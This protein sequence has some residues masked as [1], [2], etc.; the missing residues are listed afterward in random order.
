MLE[1][2]PSLQHTILCEEDYDY[3]LDLCQTGGKPVNFI[4]VI[5]GEL[6]LWFKK[7][8]L[9]YSEDLGGVPDLDPQRVVVLQGPVSVYHTRKA[10]E[11]AA[12][13]LNGVITS[14]K[15]Q[16]QTTWANEVGTSTPSSQ[17]PPVAWVLGG[18][19]HLKL[20]STDLGDARITR[21]A[22]QLQ[23]RIPHKSST[24]LPNPEAWLAALVPQQG[25]WLGA[26][27]TCHAVSCGVMVIDNPV[28]RLLAPSPGQSI[29]VTLD[30]LV[31]TIITVAFHSPDLFHFPTAKASLKT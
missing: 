21:S 11:P 31:L 14:Y 22:T 30:W 2:H 7:D 25:T 28:L 24:R 10:N 23:A 3:F 27:L 6:S 18:Q 9:W 17:A 29:S 4:P 1:A 12:E 19:V 20:A 15:E 16:L 13:V 8:S 26:L 5:D